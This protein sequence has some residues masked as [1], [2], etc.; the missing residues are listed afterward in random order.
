MEPAVGWREHGLWH[1]NVIISLGPAAVKPAAEWRSTIE[2]TCQRIFQPWPQWSPPALAHQRP[3]HQTG[4]ARL[5]RQAPAARHLSRTH[6]ARPHPA[7]SP[8]HRRRPSPPC[9]GLQHRPHQ[10]DGLRKRRPQPSQQP[11]RTGT[12][13]PLE[14]S[15]RARRAREPTRTVAVTEGEHPA[16]AAAGCSRSLPTRCACGQM[17]L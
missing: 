15:T 3:G 9:P 17:I 11:S 10:R 6:P 7:G 12:V 2:T 13:T 16:K 8:G 1:S 4:L 5:P 14:I